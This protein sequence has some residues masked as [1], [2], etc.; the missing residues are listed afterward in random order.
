MSGGD[1]IRLEPSWKARVGDYLLRP[2]MRALAEFLRAERRAGKVIYPPGPEIFA[3][4][5]HTPFDAVRVVILGQD[6]YHGPG[7]AHGLCFSVSPGVPP[8]PSLV[9]IFREIERDLGIPP[10]DHGC[11]I[12][13]ADRGVLLLNAVLTVEQGRAGS[14]Q[15]KGWEGFTDAAI[16][17]L[18]REREGLVFMLW[19]S[20]AQRKGQLIDTRRHL[21]LK[22][23]HPS[24]LSAHRGF[25]GCGHFSRANRYLEG[26]G[27]APVDWSLPPRAE[28]EAG[29]RDR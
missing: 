6:P 1:R 27:L 2:D 10:P 12:P 20:Y 5:D 18:N 17:A 28:L 3:A 16:D 23:V 21:V 22:T 24:P 13:W 8:P 26:R 15:G 14:H 29:L 11:L 7:Q 9:N 4:F 19:G 25:I